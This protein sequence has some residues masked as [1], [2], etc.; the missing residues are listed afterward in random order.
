MFGPMCTHSWKLVLST[1]SNIKLLTCNDEQIQG[2]FWSVE[3]KTSFRFIIHDK[4]VHLNLLGSL[5]TKSQINECRDCT[6]LDSPYMIDSSKGMI[7]EKSSQVSTSHNLW[8]ILALSIH[9]KVLTWGILKTKKLFKFNQE[10]IYFSF[11]FLF[12]YFLSCM[13]QHLFQL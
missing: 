9:V 8:L 4:K 6:N 11:S 7:Q 13:Q 2:N 12:I 3:G 5:D 10:Y 1:I